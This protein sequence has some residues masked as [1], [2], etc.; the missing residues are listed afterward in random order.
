MVAAIQNNNSQ[1]FI[2]P[3]QNYCYICSKAVLLPADL[4]R[5]HYH[6]CASCGRPF[7]TR[8]GIDFLC[9]NC[10]G[11]LPDDGRK[12]VLSGHLKYKQR[13]GGGVAMVIVGA[14][15]LACGGVFLGIGVNDLG[16]SDLGSGA[17]TMII[18]YIIIGCAG[19]AGG[20]V[21]L[22]LGIRNLIKAPQIFTNNIKQI[23]EKNGIKASAPSAKT[24]TT[25]TTTASRSTAQV[26][27]P[28]QE[29]QFC[30]ACGAPL[31]AGAKFCDKCGQKV[32]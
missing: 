26:D 27:E 4:T 22:L 15:L 5:P 6:I 13:I 31:R 18:I 12:E 19:L 3:G 1:N 10:M 17:P 24:T 21:L 20:L 7:C 16:Y 8:C 14:F 29:A 11:Q 30:A 25:E 2:K 23:F 28:A 32:E 9:K